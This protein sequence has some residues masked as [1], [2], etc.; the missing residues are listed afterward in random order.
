MTTDAGTEKTIRL[1]LTLEAD[2]LKPAADAAKESVSGIGT[3]AQQTAAAVT[4]ALEQAQ[5][6]M[7]D[8]ARTG[9][10]AGDG[11]SDGFDRQS[12]AIERLGETADQQ[13]DRLRA[14]VRESLAAKEAAGGIEQSQ[15]ALSERA[16]MTREQVD[17]LNRSLSD[18]ANS[19]EAMRARV[20]ALTAS[21]ERG[22]RAARAAGDGAKSES[23]ALETLLGKIDPVARKLGE[24]DKLEEQLRRHRSEGRI[25]GDDFAEYLGKIEETR[26]KLGG[27]KDSSDGAADG[28]AHFSLQ[29]AGARRELGVMIGEIARGNFGALERSSITLANRTGLMGMVFTGTGAAVAGTTAIIAGAAAIYAQHEARTDAMN[30][31]LASTGGFAAR[32]DADLRNLVSTIGAV[33]GAYAEAQ[34]AVVRLVA[35]GKLAGETLDTA[36]RGA[37]ALASITG[38]SVDQAAAK[39]ESLANGPAEAVLKLD[40]GLHFLTV[41]TYDQIKALQEQGREQEATA[42]AVKTAADA[43]EARSRDV[44]ENLG[45]IGKAAREAKGF[46]T[47]LLDALSRIGADATNSDRLNDLFAQRAELESKIG[48]L[49]SGTGFGSLR[50]ESWRLGRADQLRNDLAAL[51]EQIGKLRDVGEQQS[52]NDREA[53]AQ[54]NAEANALAASK[55][56]D[57]QALSLDKMAR[58]QRDVDALNARF[59][60]MW[61]GNDAGANPRLAD[62]LRNADG[63]FAGGLYDKLRADIDKK[64][65]DKGAARTDASQR[66][67]D[68]RTLAQVRAE[69]NRQ[70]EAALALGDRLAEGYRGPW[71]QA[72]AEYAKQLDVLGKGFASLNTQ[73]NLGEITPQQYAT[74]WKALSDAVADAGQRL[75]E[76]EQQVGSAK[77]VIAGALD[78]LEQETAAH[79]DST[80]AIR[81][82][83]L[84]RQMEQKLIRDGLPYTKAQIDA[85]REE[86]KAKLALAQGDDYAKRLEDEVLQMQAESAAHGELTPLMEAEQMIRK[87]GLDQLDLEIEK[88]DALIARIKKSAAELQS[89][90]AAR[91]FSA[92]LSRV[93]TDAASSIS[94][95]TNPFVA[96]RDA[97]MPALADITKQ[98]GNIVEANRDVTTG[99]VDWS[100]A[101]E[102][103][104]EKTK[105]TLPALGQLLGAVAMTAVGGKEG[106]MLSGALSGAASGASYGWWG[107]AIGAVLGAALGGMGGGNPAIYGSSM[108]G[109]T[110]RNHSAPT[111]TPLGTFT[112]D[113]DNLPDST[114]KQVIAAVKGFDVQLARILDADQLS[115]VQQALKGWKGKFGDVDAL[116]Q[117]RLDTI[118]GALDAGIGDFVNGFASDL[119]GRMQALSDVLS[120]QKLIDSG[121]G[122]SGVDLTTTLSLISQY[123]AAGERVTDTYQRL[124][125]ATDAYDAG[126]RQMGQTFDG[127]REAA[128][129]FA[130]DVAAAAGGAE[131]ATALWASYREQFYDANEQATADIAEAWRR[132]FEQLEGIGL[133]PTTTKAEFRALFEQALPTLTADQ[134]A[135]WLEAGK[136]LADATNAQEAYT[137]ALADAHADYAAFIGDLGAQGYGAATVSALSSQMAQIEKWKTDSIARANELARAAGMQGAAEKDLVLIRTIAEGRI[138]E[139]IQQL[140]DSTSD[141]VDQFYGRTQAAADTAATSVSRFGTAMTDAANAARSAAELL[142]GNKSP[143]DDRQKLDYAVGAYQ[144]GLVGKD[145]V[146]EIARRLYTTSQMY[147]D[148]FWRLQQMP[149]QQMRGDDYSSGQA[150][151]TTQATAQNSEEA[152]RDRRA[153]AETI[154]QNIGSVAA[155]QEQS[156]QDIADQLH[157]RLGDLASALGMTQE[158]FT[159]YLDNIKAQETAVQDSIRAGS[160]EIVDAIYD[161]ADR[162]RPTDDAAPS[163]LDLPLRD[164]SGGPGTT[165]VVEVMAEVRSLLQTLVDTSGAGVEAT[166]EVVSATHALD[167]TIQRATDSGSVFVSR[168]GR[169]VVPS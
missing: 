14:M 8:F 117:S 145:E 165:A 124:A 65:E 44:V 2:T 140:M 136:A 16:S 21:Q 118:L 33:D 155:I 19:Q 119:Q 22:E 108:P 52:K 42:L 79:G 130:M 26:A 46:V 148:F 94:S 69:A 34:Q 73:L 159:A 7:E 107:A 13:T 157:V 40:D 41:S 1:R 163:L 77:A 20:D 75:D 127:S 162:E 105:D 85:Y 151:A 31:A 88:R 113:T 109:G 98:I 29:T 4:T 53:A 72:Q 58:K 68:E 92:D 3:A 74:R 147:T 100:K 43:F 23:D 12:A 9:S 168:N 36:A 30:R 6:K 55:A 121:N 149:Q 81:S 135:R 134:V 125:S 110:S 83:S 67:Q 137:K 56:I 102:T 153:L 143:L 122:I 138:R 24:L 39:F 89:E 17:A 101:L 84:A 96:L 71:A 50:P 76:T 114:Y 99:T 133:D 62:V 60:Q 97:A 116:L 169:A 115:A 160:D 95:G 123:A 120:V 87:L 32:S 91:Q 54:R 90:K 78:A 161:V 37:V 25:G 158:D 132:A 63:S 47:D 112:S 141:L 93:F 144:R 139:A 154:T 103:L 128:V 45:Y 10:T 15:R 126:L 164:V 49:T 167:G 64:Y 59:A 57:E 5:R 70:A 38:E 82:A 18:S 106:R 27:L 146:L 166:R 152:E 35:G 156:Y 129:R 150:A 28:M 66:A 11:A 80:A 131:R 142:I 104:G 48:D 86:A 61:E 51:D 111:D